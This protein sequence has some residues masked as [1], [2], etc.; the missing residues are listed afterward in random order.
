MHTPLPPAQAAGSEP[1][2]RTL[3]VPPDNARAPRASLA[4]DCRFR[5]SRIRPTTSL[6]REPFA[7]DHHERETRR[8]RVDTHEHHVRELEQHPDENLIDAVCQWVLKVL[9]GKTFR[10]L[11]DDQ[12]LQGARKHLREA[13]MSGRFLTFK[14]GTSSTKIEILAHA[15]HHFEQPGNRASQKLLEELRHYGSSYYNRAASMLIHTGLKRCR[16]FTPFKNHNLKV[17][18]A[19]EADARAFMTLYGIEAES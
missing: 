5:F 2:R 18:F 16:S 6:F 7:G 15:A 1:S 4:E 11:A 3:F 9:G 8:Y 13:K 17:A 10:Q 19:T 14:Y 12:L